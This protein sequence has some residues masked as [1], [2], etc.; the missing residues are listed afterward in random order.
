MLQ[1]KH[2]LLVSIL[3]TLA[4]FFPSLLNDWVNWDDPDFVFNNPL[5]KDVSFVGFKN[6]FTTNHTTGAFIPLVLLSWM[7]DYSIWGL[8]PLGF[9]ITNLIIHL[10][11]V[12][13]VY[14]LVSRLTTKHWILLVTTLLF[15]LHPMRVEAVAW[16]TARK[17]LLYTLFFL[18]SLIAYTSF[19]KKHIRKQQYKYY[20]LCLIAFIAALFSKGTAVILPL[21]LL[22]F[23]YYFQRKLSVK[24]FLE[25]IP[26]MVFG[27]YFMQVAIEAQYDTGAIMGG[28][29]FSYTNSIF[30]GFYGYFVYIV[31][32]IFPYDLCAYNP[33]PMEVNEPN[34]WYFYP[35]AVCILILTAL[36]VIKRKKWFTVCFGFAFFF[37]SLIPVIQVLPIG[38]AI[39]SDRFTYLPYFGLFFIIGY[40]VDFLMR[41]YVNFK[42]IILLAGIAYMLFLGVLTFNQSR[43]WKDSDTM[44]S[45]VI[46]EFPEDFLGYY[47]RAS[48]FSEKGEDAIALKDYN[49]AIE[50][51]PELHHIHYSRA[52]TYQQLGDTLKA[53]QGYNRSLKI[54]NS[55]VPAHLNRGILFMALN[56]ED[57]AIKD[58]NKMI[59]L[60]PENHYGY[61]NRAIYY[62]KMGMW[63]EEI[64][65]ITKVI[66]LG[67]YLPSSYFNRAEAYEKLQEYNK[68]IADYE[69]VISL[70]PNNA[71]AYYAKGN[72]LFKLGDLDMAVSNY[73]KAI[74]YNKNFLNAYINRGIIRLNRKE[75][76]NALADMNKAVRI[77]STYELALLNRALIFKSINQIEAAKNDLKTIL[78]R[79]PGHVNAQN[80]LNKLKDTIE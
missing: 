57:L 67:H 63:T 26:F 73:N 33:Y 36:L 15:G 78:M 6:L 71:D 48:Y 17:D 35:M 24:L 25:K 56:K 11:N 49:K 77:D 46:E 39:T 51:K 43:T 79:N 50:I 68:A 30:V 70:T 65:D 69:K 8:N 16:I 54:D 4:A 66:S 2:I 44:W 1:K 21:V 31:K 80:E 18:L 64:K 23:D 19:I 13:L 3:A 29:T 59:A 55:F 27:V 20:I 62:K 42:K 38:T 40:A 61:F 53:L 7:I 10:I 9:H 5:I 52:Y 75:F 74:F 12:V 45:K 34:P 47:N 37:V 41:H 28:E 58:F 22:V 76:D 32:A 60:E 14:I 72:V